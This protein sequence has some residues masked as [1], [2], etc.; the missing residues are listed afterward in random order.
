[1]NE[2]AQNKI[3]IYDF[4]EPAEEE[5]EAKLLKQI[6]ARVPFAVVG[7]NTVIEIEGGKK[8]R[9]RRYPWGVVESN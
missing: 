1:M 8:I 3:R 9:G 6:R 2:I 5:E 7:A 4:P